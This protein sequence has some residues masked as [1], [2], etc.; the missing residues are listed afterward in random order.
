M[1]KEKPPFGIN[2]TGCY[3]ASVPTSSSLSGVSQ[4]SAGSGL[5]PRINNSA[6]LP[7][8]GFHDSLSDLLLDDFS[9]S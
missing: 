1:Q 3:Q 6:K 9:S 4:V 5:S 7:H 8:E 2:I